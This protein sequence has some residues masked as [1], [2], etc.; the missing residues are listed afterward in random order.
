MLRPIKIRHYVAFMQARGFRP[1][2]T[3]RGSGIDEKRLS[4]PSALIDRTQCEAVVSNIIRL[5]KNQGIAF[6]IG[7]GAKLSDFGVVAQAMISSPTL[8]DAIELWLRYS[9]LVGMLIHI[10]LVQGPRSE[11]TVVFSA[12]QPLGFIYNFCVEEILVAGVKLGSALG[13]S[14]LAVK[15]VSLSYPAPLHARLYREHLDC[16]V[17]F[18]ASRSSLT[19]RSPGLGNRLPGYDPELNEVYRRHCREVLQQIGSEDPAIARLRALFLASPGVLPDLST[20]AQRLGWTPRTLRRRLQSEGAS[21]QHLLDRFRAEK[22]AEYLRERGL[23]PKE[24]A[25]ILGFEDTNSLRRAFKVWTGL[26]LGNYRSQ[27][28][29]GTAPRENAANERPVISLSG[30][31]PRGRRSTL[32]RPSIRS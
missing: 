29:A 21:F 19:V 27:H 17:H 30:D 14:P 25:T 32:R 4:D 28:E 8:G 26:T 24:I 10:T 20:A 7:S 9:N 13:N 3:L 23:P 12:T 31:R 1:A 15:E 5:T 11:W 2:E 6:E 16:P 18:N 22:C